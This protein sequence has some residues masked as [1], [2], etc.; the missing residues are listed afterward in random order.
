LLLGVCMVG[1]SWKQNI[2]YAAIHMR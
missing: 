1:T 2:I